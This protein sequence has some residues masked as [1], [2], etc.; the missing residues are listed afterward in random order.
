MKFGFLGRTNKL[1][2]LLVAAGSLGFLAS[3]ILTVDKFRMLQDPNFKPTCSINP[4]LSCG[5][6]M[7][8]HQASVFGFAN[9]LI[10]VSAFSALS[11]LGLALLAGARFSKWFWQLIQ[12]AAIGGIIFSHWLIYQ[13]IYVLN[14]LCPFCIVVWAV[15][16]PTFLYITLYNIGSGNLGF[17]QGS[18]LA[19]FL[20]AHHADILLA[21]YLL[22]A[23][24]VLTHF[25]Y[26]WKTLL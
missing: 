25:W 3:F 2:M 26:Y 24:M 17:K 16:I 8:S 19:R 18:S 11:L 7:Q 12:V 22:V 20:R 4:I 23:A 14:T 15:T 9:S 1:A 13:S 6:V 10:G 21:W 5:S